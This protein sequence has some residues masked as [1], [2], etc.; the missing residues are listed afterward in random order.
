MCSCGAVDQVAA[1]AAPTSRKYKKLSDSK[2]KPRSSGKAS[3]KMQIL[4][5]RYLDSLSAWQVSCE[6]RSVPGGSLSTGCV[7]P[8]EPEEPI[9]GRVGPSAGLSG[10]LVMG[11]VS[12]CDRSRFAA[13]GKKEHEVYFSLSAAREPPDTGYKGKY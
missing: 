8:R 1:R 4:I 13:K 5:F 6:N 10:V 7:A 11:D 9:L 3:A 2:A 12:G